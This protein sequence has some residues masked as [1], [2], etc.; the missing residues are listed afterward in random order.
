MSLRPVH[1]R[2]HR[3]NS[4]SVR[5]VSAERMKITFKPL[6]AL[7]ALG[8]LLIDVGFF[9][10]F[11]APALLWSLGISMIFWVVGLT[12]SKDF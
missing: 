5:Q 11:G 2:E 3:G 9:I 7:C 4:R 8:A 6:P 10:K 12:M 1:G